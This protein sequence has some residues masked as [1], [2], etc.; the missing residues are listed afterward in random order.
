MSFLM[1]ALQEGEVLL[2]E[3]SEVTLSFGELV[4]KGGWVMVPIILLSLIAIYIFVERWYV[5][6]KAGKE[7]MNFMDRIKDYIYDGKI[8]A[9]SDLCKSSKSPASNMVEKG[10]T[11]IGRPLNDVNTA[12]ENV[13]KLEVYKLEKGLPTLATI[14]GAAP[15]IGFLGTV[16]GM[17]KAFY[18]M[19]NAGNNID[20]SLLSNGIYTAMVTTVA[21]LIV[22]ILAYFAYNILVAKVEKVIFRLEAT[23]SEFMDILN[24]PVK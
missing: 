15:M 12:I 17:I 9:A 19:S 24:E 6:S 20:V 8:E 11:R 4:L 16:I 1:M 22:G 2:E 10:I 23:S 7:D 21:G 14:A 5:I 13:G 18:D 3:G